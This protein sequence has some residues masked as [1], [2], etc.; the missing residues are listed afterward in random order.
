M[1]RVCVCVCVCV[2]VVC[3]CVCVSCVRVCACVV[4]RA[5]KEDF[6]RKHNL[7][8]SRELP[9][10][11]ME[12]KERYAERHKLESRDTD[13]AAEDSSGD[14]DKDAGEP[15]PAKRSRRVR[16]GPK[17]DLELEGADAQPPEPSSD[18]T[19]EPRYVGDMLMAFNFLVSYRY[20][21]KLF[22][23]HRLSTAHTAHTALTAHARTTHDTRHDTRKRA[24]KNLEFNARS[25]WGTLRAR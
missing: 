3:V 14:E 25:R 11:L 4:C 16:E 13:G 5:Q 15:S 2:C 24:D 7:T 6:C 17:D 22:F 23:I 8:V 1:C 20:H 9:A 10:A 21:T 12:A 19:I 18:F